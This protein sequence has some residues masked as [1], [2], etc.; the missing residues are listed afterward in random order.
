MLGRD[1]AGMIGTRREAAERAAEA[2]ERAAEAAQGAAE[3]AKEWAEFEER[4]SR[5]TAE[6]EEKIRKAAE[7]EAFKRAEA[8]RGAEEAARGAEE[9]ARGARDTDVR[10]ERLWTDAEMVVMNANT[11]G[12]PR[13]PGEW[14]ERAC[15]WERVALA[16]AAAAG[17][18]PSGP[19]RARRDAGVRMRKEK[20]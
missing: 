6:P 17:W 15:E 14:T 16:W 9:A 2:A 3:D 7:E 12:T 19:P 1:T 18:R 10:P 11:S 8:V 20:Q 13:S 4:K 5:S